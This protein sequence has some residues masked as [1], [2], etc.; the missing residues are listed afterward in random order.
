VA[1]SGP[2]DNYLSWGTAW[3]LMAHLLIL[4]SA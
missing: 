4:A 3:C 1:N 2:F